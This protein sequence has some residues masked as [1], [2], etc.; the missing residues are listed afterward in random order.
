M[1]NPFLAIVSFVVTPALSALLR[2]VVAKSA[3]LTYARQQAA[4]KAM[5]F[6]TERLS[7]VR[8][9][10]LF[11]AE[12]REGEAYKALTY[13]GYT[14]AEQCATFQGIVEGAG[15]LA[16]NVGTLSLLALGG[17]LVLSGRI[18]LGTLLAFNVYNLFLSV[19]LASLA[20][21][22]GEMGKAVGAMERIAEVVGA[23]GRDPAA[24]TLLND[25]KAA[26]NP[27]STTTTSPLEALPQPSS[28]S[29]SSSSTT[30]SGSSVEMKDVWFKYQGRE[31]WALRGLT[32]NIVSGS[33]VALVGPSGG[34]KS[35]TVALLLGLYS[36]Q[37]GTVLIDD[38]VLNEETI[39]A[40][41]RS[42][43]TVLQQPSLLAGTVSDQIRMGN[44]G[45]SDQEVVAAA[46]AANAVGFISTLPAGFETALGERGHQLSGGQQQRLS[47]ARAL[48]RKPRL[49]LLDEPTA[50]LDVDAER[51]VDEALQQVVGCTKVII[52]H[53]LST[54][55]R[56]DSIAVV[57]G[58][59]VVEQG[60]HEV[61]MQI[62]G[63]VYQRMVMNSELGGGGGNNGVIVDEDAVGKKEKE[64]LEGKI[65]AA[66]AY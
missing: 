60:S 22:L 19:G 38:V 17:V 12:D 33:T 25:P 61:L 31:D 2:R 49:L 32:L 1:K 54:V 10:Q 40:T 58:G 41:R 27:N 8:T 34:G 30:T 39:P 23:G 55:R 14:L 5:E 46:R 4:A 26:S 47:I 18:S 43:G 62:E 48:V 13:K 53:R 15:R 59:Q 51:A 66:R 36:P 21:S 57:V 45:A 24:K 65:E 64:D 20:G 35:T 9:V 50:A 63:G 7:N 37:Q 6:A 3:K 44:P 29:S 28:S 42:I 11:A 16:V 56:A 52:A